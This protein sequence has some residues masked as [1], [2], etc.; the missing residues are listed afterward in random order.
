MEL[1]QKKGAEQYGSRKKKKKTTRKSSR[2]FPYQL[3]GLVA[4]VEA[5]GPLRQQNINKPKRATSEK[6]AAG[7]TATEKQQFGQSIN[8][9]C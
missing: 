9:G 1:A 3:E 6:E 8:G 2:F 7:L 4:K 5:S